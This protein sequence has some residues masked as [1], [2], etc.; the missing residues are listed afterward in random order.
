MGRRLNIGLM[1]SHLEDDF[2]SAVCRGAIIAAKEIDANL[3]IIPG[4]YIDGYYVDF[5]HTEYEYQYNTMFS[6]AFPDDIDVLL[7]LTGAIT[8]FVSKER[9]KEF[10]AQFKG[11]P[12]I[13]IASEVE[14]YPS[15]CFDNKS[16]LRECIEHLIKEHGCKKIGFVSGAETNG[17]AVERLEVYRETLRKFDIPIVEERIAYG[18][19]S[20][21]SQQVVRELLDRCPDLDAIAFANDP[22]ASG[23]Y[24]V[25]EERSI[26]VGR[27]IFITGFD[28][29]PIAANLMPPLTTASADASGLGYNA[30]KGCP[31][32]IETGMLSDSIVRSAMV[33]RK[34]CGCRY[35]LSIENERDKALVFNN[36]MCRSDDQIINAISRYLFENYKTSYRVAEAKPALE[37]FLRYVLCQL[38]SDDNG[39]ITL[40]KQAIDN[41]PSAFEALLTPSVM[42]Y[43]D[44]D[45]FCSVIDYLCK[46]FMAGL[47]DNE[48]K[49]RLSDLNVSMYQILMRAVVNG[50]NKRVE[51]VEFLAFQSN[52]ITKDMLLFDSYDDLGYGSVSDKL[53]RFNMMASSYIYIFQEVITHR[54]EHEWVPPSKVLLK[55]YHINDFYETVPAEEQEISVRHLFNHRYMPKDRRFTMVLSPIYLNADH[56]GLFLCETELDY[57]HYINSLLAQLSAA[58]KILKLIQDKET[59]Q[60]ELEQTLSQL[61]Q[62]NIQLDTI[63]KIDELSGVYNRRGFFYQANSVICSP[64]NVGRDAIILFADLDDLKVINDR[65]SHDNGDFAI[66]SVAEILRESFRS[67][68]IIGRI[69]GDEFAVFALLEGASGD[70]VVSAVRSRIA[71]STDKFNQSHNKG[72]SVHMSVGVHM[73]R[74]DI[75]VELSKILVEADNLLYDEKKNKKSIFR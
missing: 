16:G 6:Y 53:M 8:N 43:V 41:I 13:T 63:A 73:F 69:G 3:I 51:E 64:D 1:I 15:V 38:Q 74:C 44:H 48:D 40:S 70:D 62:R 27:D 68:D 37:R 47:E 19:F 20:P 36:T 5:I 56:Y 12:V 55:S 18:N 42:R 32:Y 2:A 21:Y 52:C 49:S 57:F 31:E 45:R 14:G 17:D 30:V 4:R 65:F 67:T 59:I 24:D 9:E 71:E 39:G 23:A 33:K 72:Y 28:D 54:K 11:I 58:I 25:F 22:M 10:L 60:L 61:E 26:E 7:V 29:S 35:E 46:R 66:R 34:S 75:D 50:N